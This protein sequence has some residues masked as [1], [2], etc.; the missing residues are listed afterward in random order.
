VQ[1][2]LARVG[3][4]HV[5]LDRAA[6]TVAFDAA[7]V[8]LDPG[9]IGKGYAVDRMVAVLGARGVRAAFVSAGGSSMFGL[10]TPPDDP[11]GWRATIRD[12]RDAS[13]AAAEVWLDETSLSTSGSYEKF[14][15]AGGQVYSHI[16]DPRT[17]AP[18]RGSS[19]VSVLAPRAID[20]E[21]W[22]KAYFVHGRAWAGRHR[23]PGTR[24]FICDDS[25]QAR[26]TW[27]D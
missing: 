15:R 2:A 9:G 25:P 1:R 3:P 16:I 12:P 5:R 20:G 4:A 13:R 11:R 18:A 24:A 7:G 10:G 14:F 17:G 26:C 22:T 8:E 21:A 27:I 23:P 6:R 19:S